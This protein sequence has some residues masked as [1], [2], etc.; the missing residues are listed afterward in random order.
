ML[1]PDAIW[2]HGRRERIL[3]IAVMLIGGLTLLVAICVNDL[4][5][6]SPRTLTVNTLDQPW[7]YLAGL[8]GICWWATCGEPVLS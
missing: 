1:I 3:M 4:I 5:A 8:S 2:K 6:P 7:Q